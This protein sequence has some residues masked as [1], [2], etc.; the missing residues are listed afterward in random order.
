MLDLG[1]STDWSGQGRASENI[2]A[3]NISYNTYYFSISS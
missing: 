1:I 3:F 2:K